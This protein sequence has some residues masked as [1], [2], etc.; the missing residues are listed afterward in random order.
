VSNPVVTIAHAICFFL[1]D[2]DWISL[3]RHYYHAFAWWNLIAGLALQLLVLLRV[4]KFTWAKSLVVDFSTSAVSYVL[5]VAVIPCVGM[6]CSYLALAAANIGKNS[7]IVWLPILF[8]LPLI[9]AAAEIALLRIVFQQKMNLGKFALL[10]LANALAFWAGVYGAVVYY[11]AH[12]P[13]A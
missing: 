10:L 1:P 13:Q 5:D 12:P 9:N 7:P 4:F 3:Y 6:V 8:L 2:A 11:Y